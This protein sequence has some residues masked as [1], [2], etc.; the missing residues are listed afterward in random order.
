MS[1][2]HT[3][4]D[5]SVLGQ[6]F[7]PPWIVEK[8]L[9]LSEH[10]S[11]GKDWRVLEPSCGNGAFFHKI[12]G[13]VGLEIDPTHCPEEAILGDFFEYVPNQPFD[14]IIG[15]P[16]FVRF[17][18]IREDTRK[19]L[20]LDRFD[21]RT[22]LYVFFIDKAIDLLRDKGELI[23]INPRDF[24]KSTSARILNE[25]IM[26]S[27]TITHIEDLGDAK[28]FSGYAPNCVIWRFVKGDFS[29]KTEDGRKMTL[30]GG[31][32]SFIQNDY[33]YRVSDF[34][35]VK[36]GGVSGADPLF[37]APPGT[38]T[39][40]AIEFVY[41]KT[42]D[43]HQTRLMY[44]ADDQG[45][46]PEFLLRHEQALRARKIK[47]F[48]DKN[49]WHWGRKTPV[50]DRPRVYV[51]NKTRRENPFF[52]HEAKNFVG[53]VFGLMIKNPAIS[54]VQICNAMNAVNWSELGFVT[55]GRFIFS[56]R[57]LMNAPLPGCFEQ[58]EDR[59]MAGS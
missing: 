33:P 32:I 17:Q 35:D 58:F 21:E 8:M 36:V 48:D 9:T 52:L 30:S 3:P 28:I 53:S 46:P 51:N 16:P 12:K 25:K 27:G 59:R 13:C 24:L 29:H 56:Q 38:R 37:T 44:Y 34:F 26:Q 54:P 43:T 15:N 11:L 4:H 39:S 5:V 6:V 41:S 22:N 57:S 10:R 7:T 19:R 14:T 1:K 31:N 23:F 42:I 40:S 50:D 55:G 45:H 18:D 20:D 49:W 47:R 2:N